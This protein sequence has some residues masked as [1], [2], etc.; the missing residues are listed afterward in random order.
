MRIVIIRPCCIG[1]VVMATAALSAL[2]RTFENAHITFAVGQWSRE[3]VAFHPQVNAILD[4]GP[5]DMP[6]KSVRGFTKFVSDLRAGQFDVAVSLVRSP[7]MSLAVLLSGIRV[8]AGIASGWR[9]F[10]YNRR[11]VIT[12]EATRHEA[13][14]YLDVVRSMGVDTEGCLANVPVPDQAHKEIDQ[15]LDRRG[16]RRPYLVINP[17]GGDNPGMKFVSKRWPTDNFAMLADLLADSY[18][19]QVVLLGGP[20]DSGLVNTVRSAMQTPVTPF[21]GELS[22]AQ[23]AA[24][25]AGSA[26]YVGNDTGLTHLAAAAGAPTAAI[27]GPTDPRRYMP[28]TRQTTALWQP[29]DIEA[30]G[31]AHADQRTGFD[32]ARDGISVGSALHQIHRFLGTKRNIATN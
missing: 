17:T 25:A 24:L 28:F 21:I 30:G 7:L 13:D 9:G 2:R 8:R 29:I 27:F 31:V 20:K 4:T 1:D 3:A 6:V 22:F 32:W 23:I 18:G 12:P 15:L 19:W 10:G 26:L 11:A 16:V 14:I 5:A